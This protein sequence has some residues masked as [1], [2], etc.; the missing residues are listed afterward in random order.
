MLN[1]DDIR[2]EDIKTTIKLNG[3]YNTRH[4]GGYIGKDGRVTDEKSFIRSDVPFKITE[5][6]ITMLVK[7]GLETVLDLRT[8]DE[9]DGNPTPFEQL[10]EVSYVTI[11]FISMEE[12]PPHLMED[13]NLGDLYV[14][15]LEDR[16]NQIAEALRIINRTNGTV[17]FNCSAGKDRTGVLAMLLLKIAG[18]SDSDIVKDYY[19]TEILLQPWIEKNVAKMKA[20]G[21]NY[22]IKMLEA[23]PENMEVA[24]DHLEKN[25][26][27]INSYFESLDINEDGVS[28]L[29]EKVLV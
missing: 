12:T 23:L 22:N 7:R 3:T 10:A 1:I 2:K 19:F 4:I 14:H 18:V 29:I 5:D 6:D 28:K 8:Q 26:S 17:F 15:I 13:G 20:A 25:Y 21:I 24:L 16:K 11:P 9:I 27:S